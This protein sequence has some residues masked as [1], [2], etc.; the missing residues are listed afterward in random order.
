MTASAASHPA[1]VALSDIRL[2]WKQGRAALLDHFGQHPQQ[3]TPLL[4]GLTRLADQ[5]LQTLWTTSGMPPDAALIA[6]GGYGR[7]ELF[8]FSDIDLL[9]LLEQTQ[10]SNAAIDAAASGFITACWDIGLEIGRACAPSRPA[11]T[12]PTKDVTVQTALLES[13]FCAATAPWLIR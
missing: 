13:R 5:T 12:K 2:S 3:V 8:P 10:G 7:G 1:E 4:H 9:L 6:V 11:S